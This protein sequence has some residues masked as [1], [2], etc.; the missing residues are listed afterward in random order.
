MT[1]EFDMVSERSSAPARRRP[2]DCRPVW[3]EMV[4]H[5]FEKTLREHW[6]TNPASCLRTENRQKVEFLPTESPIPLLE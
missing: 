4:P 2:S 5:W 1:S 3:L 6:V